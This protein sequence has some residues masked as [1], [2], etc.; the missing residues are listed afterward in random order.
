[1]TSH[2]E[3][4]HTF[5]DLSYSVFS[6]E[7]SI[8]LIFAE[9]TRLKNGRKLQMIYNHITEKNRDCGKILLEHGE[10]FIY[11]SS[12]TGMWIENDNNK[13]ILTIFSVA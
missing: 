11:S 3:Q 5:Q 9:T 6:D 7:C 13:N 12:P 10:K 1:M 8:F 4:H 2:R